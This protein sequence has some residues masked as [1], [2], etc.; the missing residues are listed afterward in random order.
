MFKRLR[1]AILI[2]CGVF[3]ALSHGTRAWAACEGLTGLDQARCYLNQQPSRNPLTSGS[4]GA[5]PST[6]VPQYDPSAPVPTDLYST[7]GNANR[8]T[9]EGNTA[10]QQNEM[11]PSLLRSR[12]DAKAWSLRDSPFMLNGQQALQSVSPLAGL[13]QQCSLQDVCVSRAEPSVDTVTCREPASQLHICSEGTAVAHLIAPAEFQPVDNGQHDPIAGFCENHFH[14]QSDE[15][16]LSGSC[17]IFKVPAYDTTVWPWRFQVCAKA[18]YRYKGEVFP[19]TESCLW[20]NEGEAFDRLT[21]QTYHSA[22]SGC[23]GTTRFEVT[24]SGRIA[25][26]FGEVTFTPGQGIAH[27]QT[28]GFTYV[29]PNYTVEM[30]DANG[31]PMLGCSIPD[32]APSECQAQEE[33]CTG[34]EETRVVDGVAVLIPCTS[35]TNYIQCRIADTCAQYKTQGG[36]TTVS[37]RCGQEDIHGQ[38]LWYE[39]TMQCQR[40]GS[41]LDAHQVMQCSQ[42]GTPESPVP[43]CIDT[44]TAPNRNLPLAAGYLELFQQLRRDYDPTS[45]TIFKGTPRRC[46]YQTMLEQGLS[47]TMNTALS[48]LIG[49]GTGGGLGAFMSGATA[50]A[51]GAMAG[52]IDC[53]NLNIQK[54]IST[55]TIA[56]NA[57]VH[58][59]QY[60]LEYA[61][62]AQEVAENAIQTA[63]QAIMQADQIRLGTETVSGALAESGNQAAG[64]VMSQAASNGGDYIQMANEWSVAAKEALAA[65][66]AAQATEFAEKAQEMAN[67]A[68]EVMGSSLGSA[69]SML[70]AAGDLASGLTSLGVSMALNIA[71][72]ALLDQLV[73]LKCDSDDVLLSVERNSGLAVF[74]GTRC[75][76]WL[77]LGFAKSCRVKEEV[78]C[79]FKSILARLVHQQGRPQI[80]RSF[81][82]VHDGADSPDCGGLTIPEFAAMRFDQMNLQEFYDHLNPQASGFAM[83][84]AGIR[85]ATTYIRQKGGP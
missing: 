16:G 71:K 38:C 6:V 34:V 5:Q 65:G 13:S 68:G 4:F 27:V 7:S 79:S 29:P 85:N 78:W 73:G 47:T 46:Q 69:D 3:V 75:V 60:A 66:D 80:G 77:E 51:G 2:C 54:K 19:I 52:P 31:Q 32:G 10:L 82:V 53:C 22:G 28:L 62:H 15:Y 33:A 41:C 64:E 26:G 56:A 55:V 17:Y 25:N 35:K 84:R 50:V 18:W 37:S 8:L 76:K 57:A 1:R 12:Q 61:A 20:V 43:F 49:A 36:C 42:C 11:I 63:D 30:V 59:S 44:T 24:I 83:N 67:N 14:N 23:C 21:L 45:L 9:Q 72:S 74:V 39:N 48:S 58:V 40:P 70:S 81:G